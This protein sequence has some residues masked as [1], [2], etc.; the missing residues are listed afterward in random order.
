MIAQPRQIDAIPPEPFPPKATQI[1]VLHVHLQNGGQVI[2]AGCRWNCTHTARTTRTF[3]QPL[4]HLPIFFPSLS[5]FHVPAPAPIPTPTL[6]HTY[7]HSHTH[8]HAPK[9]PSLTQLTFSIFFCTLSTHF[10]LFHQRLSQI[11]P[12]TFSLHSFSLSLSPIFV[13]LSNL[14]FISVFLCLISVCSLCGWHYLLP[15]FYLPTLHRS[16][17]LLLFLYLLCF[18]LSFFFYFS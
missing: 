13:P 18:L 6:T 8:T 4:K 16:L 10:F 7:T 2:E 14:L 17:S 5:L 1:K 9:P 15:S 12:C 3:S 11:F